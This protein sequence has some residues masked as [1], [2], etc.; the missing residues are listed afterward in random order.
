MTCAPVLHAPQFARRRMIKDSQSGC[1][2]AVEP[3]AS[4]RPGENLNDSDR[5]AN[6]H[7]APGEKVQ[8]DWCD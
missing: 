7:E 4:K 3:R 2:F 5:K 6:S 8:R 1:L